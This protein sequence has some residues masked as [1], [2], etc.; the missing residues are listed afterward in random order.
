MDSKLLQALSEPKQTVGTSIS[1]IHVLLFP[2]Q[3]LRFPNTRFLEVKLDSSPFYK[4]D[5]LFA[6]VKFYI[7]PTRLVVVKHMKKSEEKLGYHLEE[8]EM[9]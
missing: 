3:M 1:L 8:C 7:P 6:Q 5:T 4:A 9:V 2:K